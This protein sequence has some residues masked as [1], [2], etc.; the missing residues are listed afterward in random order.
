MSDSAALPTKGP[1]A[2]VVPLVLASA[3]PRR[4]ELLEITGLSFVVLP[5]GSEPDPDPGESPEAYAVRSA[6]AKA[7]E[8]AAKRSD[9]VIIAADTVVTLDDDILG[10]PADRDDALRMLR[11]LAGKRHTVLTGVVVLW[12]EKKVRTSFSVGTDVDMGAWPEEVL[13]A[14]VATGEPADKAGAYAVQ[15]KG[16]FLVESLTGSY[17]NVVG[18]PVT[19]VLKELLR[20][21]A[22]EA[23]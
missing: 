12:K 10:K 17:T 5:A 4:K 2:A 16:G 1:F 3:S 11:L 22:I 9:A 8:I 18:L 19:V 6:M 23:A 13:A 20:I 15:G 21:G 14:Y 7:E